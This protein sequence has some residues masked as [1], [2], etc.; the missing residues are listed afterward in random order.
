MEKTFTSYIKN[1]KIYTLVVAGLAGSVS[2]A[3]S[4]IVPTIVMV[5]SF[6]ATLK[7]NLNIRNYPKKSMEFY[8]TNVM[9]TFDL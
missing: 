6:I 3:G 2:W 5:A 8:Q 7:I 4:I 1:T 9:K